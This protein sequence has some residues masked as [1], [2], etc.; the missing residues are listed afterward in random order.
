MILSKKQDGYF[1]R[2]KILKVGKYLQFPS[3]SK[4]N[5]KQGLEILVMI[6]FVKLF[7]LTKRV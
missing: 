4:I 5:E 2:V 7:I 1:I 3:L 6:W